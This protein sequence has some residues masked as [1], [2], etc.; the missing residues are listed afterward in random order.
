MKIQISTSTANQRKTEAFKRWFHGSKIVDKEGNPRICYH[1]TIHNVK[2]FE[3]SHHG[4]HDFGYLGVGFYFSAR[5]GIANSYGT[6]GEG[7]NVMPVYLCLKNPYI[8]HM[9]NW[10]NNEHGYGRV[11]AISQSLQSQGMNFTEANQQAAIQYRKELEEQGYDGIVDDTDG[12]MSQIVAFFP[13]QIKSAIGNRG[14]FDPH[15]PNV[16]E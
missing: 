16:L 12:E 4:K 7:G 13:N 1:G 2:A 10:Q 11:V 14:T 6:K 15:S 5:K 8:I 9:G 3:A